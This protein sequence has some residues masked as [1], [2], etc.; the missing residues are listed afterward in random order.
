[1]CGGGDV[2]SCDENVRYGRAVDGGGEEGWRVWDVVVAV[3]GM[4]Q[5]GVLLVEGGAM[6]GGL[7]MACAGD[8]V[9]GT[10]DTRMALTETAIGVVPAQIGR[11]IIER[12][13]EFNARYIMLTAQRST[14]LEG[15][16]YW[17][18]DHLVDNMAAGEAKWAE[19][20][21]EVRR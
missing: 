14:A 16:D 6:A 17:L 5:V 3:C 1:M 11:F 13:G 10:K 8:I 4:A 9:I 12:V 2:R 20:I 21:P 18:D 19:M 7:G 15:K